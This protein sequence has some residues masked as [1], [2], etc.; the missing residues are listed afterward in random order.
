MPVEKGNTLIIP[1]P[2]GS[3]NPIR[4]EWSQS[5][6]SRAENYYSIVA[7]NE[8]QGNDAVVFFVQSNWYNDGH[9]ASIGQKVEGGY[10]VIVGDKFQYG[11]ADG[12]GKGR[13]IVYHD[14]ER[15][16]YQHRFVHTT[17]LSSAGDAAGVLAKAIGGPG[18]NAVD[19]AS[20]LGSNLFGDYLHT[21]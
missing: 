3:E 19:L 1:A 13:F 10:K 16:P 5:W 15:K 18:A 12:T 4:I 8:S 2:T 17:L 20:R 7:K 11:Q 9:L 6:S 14:K 21:F